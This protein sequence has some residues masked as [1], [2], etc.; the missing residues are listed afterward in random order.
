M[1]AKASFKAFLL[2]ISPRLFDK[3]LPVYRKSYDQ[4]WSG[5]VAEK[6]RE[7]VYARQKKDGTKPLT[8]NPTVTEIRMAFDRYQPKSV[9]EVGCGWGRLLEE[10]TPFYTIE[11]CDLSEEYLQRIPDGT[12]VF[13]C[14]I[15]RE[16]PPGRWDIVFTRAVMQYFVNDDSTLRNA[17]EHM[18]KVANKKV[19]VWEWKHVC[20]RMKEVY[21]SDTFEYYVMKYK[22]E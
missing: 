6:Y 13:R 5:T 4:Y 20:E 7:G 18:E 17:M 10:L 1:S 3:Y 2:N 14:D 8:E 15:V 22:D 21:P 12:R 16:E 9:L 19:I 11:G